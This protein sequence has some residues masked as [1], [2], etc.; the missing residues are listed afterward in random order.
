MALRCLL[1]D[2]NDAFLET[3]RDLLEREGMQVAGVAS[4]IAGALRQVRTLRPDVILVDIGLGDESGFELA[5]LL[6][7]DG[8]GGRAGVILI[9]AQAETDYSDLIAESPAAGFL[10]KPELSAQRIRQILGRTP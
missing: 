8:Q 2:D 6:A 4:N 5:R 7:A 1:V 9:S 10:P 3:A